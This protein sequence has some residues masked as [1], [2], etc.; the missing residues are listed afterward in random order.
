MLKITLSLLQ[1]AFILLKIT[2]YINWSWWLVFAPLFIYLAIKLIA[3]TI[4][5]IMEVN[6]EEKQLNAHYGKSKWQQKLDEIQ[7]K[8]SQRKTQ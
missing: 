2:D 4:V 6:K 7:R 8:Q 3:I 1:V 5:A